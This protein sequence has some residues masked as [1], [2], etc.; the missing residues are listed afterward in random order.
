MTTASSEIE[1]KIL[2]SSSSPGEPPGATSCDSK[3]DEMGNH[4]EM[5]EAHPPSEA[6][7]A[8]AGSGR[9]DVKDES[10]GDNDPVNRNLED[11][12][13]SR[14]RRAARGNSGRHGIG[15]TT[16]S[17]PRS[18]S[19]LFGH[20]RGGSLLSNR[21]D[22]FGRM[23]DDAEGGA[24]V[25]VAA[26]GSAVRRSDEGGRGLLRPGLAR[27]SSGLA[28]PGPSFPAPSPI[29]VTAPG[30]PPAGTN[31]ANADRSRRRGVDVV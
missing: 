8:E 10:P 25:R 28:P 23:G 31:G 17:Q 30:P 2:D 1:G 20:R 3:G 15:H 11:V 26:L 19:G 9:G 5:S 18:R 12:L 29:T 6:V 7:D 13:S 16:T 21:N 4:T 27:T 24:D 22:G 14:E